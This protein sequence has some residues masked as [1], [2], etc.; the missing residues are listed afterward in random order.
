MGDLRFISK[1]DK[2]ILEKDQEHETHKAPKI[3]PNYEQ[4]WPANHHC[5]GITLRVQVHTELALRVITLRQYRDLLGALPLREGGGAKHSP[6][7]G[8]RDKM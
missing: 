2:Q 7:G 5:A 8:R 6:P 4:H 3:R 1:R